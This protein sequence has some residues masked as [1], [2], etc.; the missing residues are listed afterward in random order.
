MKVLVIG[1]TGGFGS[2]ICTTLAADGHD[3]TAAGR[4]FRKGEA[5]A[6]RTPG[7]GFLTM[8]RDDVTADRLKVYD[9]VVDA[10]GPFRHQDRSLARTA[11]AAG[12]HHLDIADDRAFVRGI[13]EL[14]DEAVTAGVCCISGASSVPGL[15]SAIA[16][17]LA[18][19]METVHHIDIAISASSRAAFG[20]SV[21]HSMLS[22]AGRRIE[23]SDGSHGTAM[24]DPRTL[25][26]DHAGRTPLRRTVL[27]VDGPDQSCLPEML[28]GRPS[29]RFR[30]GG[31]LR[32][33][34]AAMRVI[35]AMTSRGWPRDGSSLAPIA[36]MARM[37]TGRMG[38][39]RSGMAVRV[40]GDVD[41]VRTSRTWSLLAERN[42]GPLI[43]SL[44]VPAL[45][46]AIAQGRV[47]PGARTAAGLIDADEVLSRMPDGSHTEQ[48][49]SDRYVPIYA[50]MAN[51][52]RLHPS[53]GKL[54]DFPS[55]SC[56]SGRADIVRGRGLAARIIASL[57]GFPTAGTDVPV[58]VRFEPDGDGER[59]TRTF[60]DRS[61]HS[62]LTPTLTGVRERFGPM[63]FRFRLEER[64]GS[65]AMVPRSWRMFGVRMPKRMMPDGVAME[66]GTDGRFTFDVPIRVPIAGM[67]VH[68]RGW[69]VPQP[70]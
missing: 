18:N 22:G 42:M 24:T 35:A 34:N 49:R 6:S 26:I 40:I 27:E 15:S 29:V 50:R 69:L 68:Y 17:G 51:H 70:R 58:T 61:F 11:I 60:G 33:H 65:L 8:D 14:D 56:A 41:G 25:R 21:L 53:I 62:V 66:R 43:P 23:R 54:H 30:A 46:A 31:E 20:R 36:R 37:L 1:G 28:P 10:A 4:D 16:I 5:F 38:D 52:A 12:C 13:A 67:V 3:V 7:V 9:V 64:G 45:V 59:W 55:V 19:G 44:V 48:V 57:F 47:G 2:T 39:G 63:S 32:I